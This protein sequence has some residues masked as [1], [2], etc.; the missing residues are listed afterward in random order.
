MISLDTADLLLLC[1]LRDDCRLSLRDLGA[2]VSMS[3]P[4][5]AARLRRLEENH[6]IEA[7]TVSVNPGTFALTVEALLYV[8]VSIHKEADF[9]SEMRK[10]LCVSSLYRIGADYTYMAVA[11]FDSIEKLNSFALNMEQN[12]GR[13]KVQLILKKEFSARAP[14][15]LLHV[16]K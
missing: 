11:S 10:T 8:C 7:Y 15:E 4:A 3:A 1:A 9:V 5:V 13:T 14:M 2:K 16:D 6:V 12:Y